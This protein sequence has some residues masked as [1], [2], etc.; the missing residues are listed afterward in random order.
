MTKYEQSGKY[1][2]LIEE[3][4]LEQFEQ[5]DVKEKEEHICQLF[6]AKQNDN[7]RISFY[8]RIKEIQA[9]E[10]MDYLV[11]NYVIVQGDA[12]KAHAVLEAV[13][14]QSMFMDFEVNSIEGL[15]EKI[16]ENYFTDCVCIYAD[17]FAEKNKDMIMEMPSY[18]KKK[19]P[20][21]YVKTTDVLQPGEK[22]YLKSLENQSRI[23]IE[24]SD[25]IIIMIGQ[26]GEIYHINREKFEKTYEASE[27]ILD[28]FEKMLDYLPEIQKYDD[29]EFISLDEVAHLCYPKTSKGVYVMPLKSRTKVFNPY[30]N[31]EYFLGQEGDFLTIRKDD[32]KDIYVIQKDIFHESYEECE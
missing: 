7:I 25:D 24:A 12:Q 11:H 6:W 3:I 2:I 13:F 17:E 21:A 22:F 5:T 14:L 28:I 16:V 9:F 18:K 1:G 19:I 26:H 31:G 20:W 8:S 32:L 10:F 27:E 29:G 23:L 30:N 4:P 15:L